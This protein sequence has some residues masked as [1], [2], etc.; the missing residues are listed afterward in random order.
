MMKKLTHSYLRD[1]MQSNLNEVMKVLQ[2][3]Y[4][5]LELRAP[6]LVPILQYPDKTPVVILPWIITLFTHSISSLSQV[7]RLF[8]VILLHPI[9][10]IY[11]AAAVVFHFRKDLTSSQERSHVYQVLGKLDKKQLPLEK[12][13][14]DAK[15]FYDSIPPSELLMRSKRSGISLD[16]N[17]NIIQYEKEM[18]SKVYRFRNLQRL[19]ESPV[20]CRIDPLFFQYS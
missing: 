2:L 20:K 11:I 17:S 4:P 1:Y 10:P 8:D 15:F 13:L 3:V 6:E 12:I 5:L 7:A 14:R 9:M 16:K 18:K 19:D